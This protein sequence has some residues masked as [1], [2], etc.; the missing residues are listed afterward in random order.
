MIQNYLNFPGRADSMV[1][2]ERAILRGTLLAVHSQPQWT[3][4]MSAR[5]REL[6]QQAIIRGPQVSAWYTILIAFKVSVG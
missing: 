1:N 5:V 6:V 2:A 4:A 3:V